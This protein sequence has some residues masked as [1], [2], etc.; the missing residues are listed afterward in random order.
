MAVYVSG[1]TDV[2]VFIHDPKPGSKTQASGQIAKDIFDH[3]N[4]LDSTNSKV[5]SISH[6]AYDYGSIW[7]VSLSVNIAII[8]IQKIGFS[9]GIVVKEHHLQSLLLTHLL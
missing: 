8:Q 7:C 2:K 3:I 6:C 1:N 9:V 4:A 5:I